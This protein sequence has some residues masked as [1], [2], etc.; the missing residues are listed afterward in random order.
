MYIIVYI[1]SYTNFKSICLFHFLLSDMVSM[2]MN[3]QTPVLY[4]LF[5]SLFE[6]TFKTFSG[7]K[8]YI[9]DLSI[10]YHDPYY[11]LSDA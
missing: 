11:G 3:Q 8:Y 5:F 1:S 7:I 4:T 2:I 10:M 6:K 9:D